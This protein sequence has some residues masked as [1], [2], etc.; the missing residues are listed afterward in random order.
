MLYVPVVMRKFLVCDCVT[1]GAL[2]FLD[3]PSDGWLSLAGVGRPKGVVGPRWASACPT[4]DRRVPPA[5]KVLRT[6][7]LNL[8]AFVVI[9]L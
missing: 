4:I 5:G 8:V 2:V 6:R 9:S 3:R 1:V 7:S